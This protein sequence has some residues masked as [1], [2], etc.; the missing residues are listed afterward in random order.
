MTSLRTGQPVSVKSDRQLRKIHASIKRYYTELISIHGAT[1][2]GVDWTCVATQE[3]RFVQLLRICDF[4]APFSLNDVGCGYGALVA[5]LRRRHRDVEIDYLGID[6][7][8][9]MVHRAGRIWKDC[10]F[11]NFVVATNSPRIADYSVA[12]GIFNVK[13]DR[14]TDLWENFI[15]N[16]LEDMCATSRRGFAVNLMAPQ[17]LEHAQE[18]DLYCTAPEPWIS[19]CEQ[20]LRRPVEVLKDYGMREFTLLAHQQRSAEISAVIRPRSKCNKGS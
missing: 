7:S 13:L 11:V 6:L 2:R 12:S 19:Y 14:P 20:K 5:Y 10:N 4:A 18:P 16:T 15:A 8:P 1:P 9:A 17:R 3:L